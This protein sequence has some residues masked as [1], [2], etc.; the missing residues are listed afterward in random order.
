MDPDGSGTVDWA[1]LV[2]V[3][4]QVLGLMD[5][6]EVPK[7]RPPKVGAFVEALHGGGENLEEDSEGKWFTG[8]VLTV[9]PDGTREVSC[10]AL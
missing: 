1:E 5:T 10:V 7:S 3:G 2:K 8:V 9:H 4:T 6:D